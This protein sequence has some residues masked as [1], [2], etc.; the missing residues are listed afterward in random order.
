MIGWIGIASARERNL[1]YAK[2]IIFLR[3]HIWKQAIYVH[4]RIRPHVGDVEGDEVRRDVVV[5]RDAD[6]DVALVVFIARN[7]DGKRGMQVVFAAGF[8][9]M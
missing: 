5:G 4:R 7:V 9:A 8:E 3:V 2:A 1:L 6:V